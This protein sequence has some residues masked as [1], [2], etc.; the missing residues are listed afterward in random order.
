MSRHPIIHDMLAE[1]EYEVQD[2]VGGAARKV[3]LRIGQ[4][5]RDPH[6]DWMCPIQVVGLD[7]DNVMEVNGI[8]AVQALYLAM[9]IAG[10]KLTYPPRGVTVTWKGERNVG[11]P[12]PNP[13]DAAGVE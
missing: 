1:R 6:G 8:D 5:R 12:L 10:A 9:Q 13:A 4:P 3:V 2:T 11:L 7:Y